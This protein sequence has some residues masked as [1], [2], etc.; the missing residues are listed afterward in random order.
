MK[1]S[2]ARGRT[3]ICSMCQINDDISRLDIT[4]PKDPVPKDNKPSYD[5]HDTLPEERVPDSSMGPTRDPSVTLRPRDHSVTS[6]PRDHSMS[7]MSRDSS[8]AGADSSVHFT[9]PKYT[10]ASNQPRPVDHPTVPTGPSGPYGDYQIPP[11]KEYDVTMR[12]HP[13][14]HYPYSRGNPDIQSMYVDPKDSSMYHQPFDPAVSYTPSREKYPQNLIS[15]G[16]YQEPKMPFHLYQQ[17]KQAPHKRVK[18]ILSQNT[19][20]KDESIQLAIKKCGT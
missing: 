10:E 17:P 15:P 5:R 14:D 11:L 18:Y 3:R 4:Q 16:Y 12:G 8:M 2:T 7:Y 9:F 1:N 19:A 6:R 20:F 13:N